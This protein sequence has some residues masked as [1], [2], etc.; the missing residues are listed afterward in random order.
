MDHRW[1]VRQALEVG[2]KLYA[3]PGSPISGQLL[4]ASSSGGYVTTNAAVPVMT[5]VHVTIGSESSQRRG[6]HRIAGYVVRTDARGVGIEWQ[7]FAPQPV[8]A[9]IEALKARPSAEGRR[10]SVGVQSPFVAHYCPRPLT[11]KQALGAVSHG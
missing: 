2:V 6:L 1:G 10:T 4:N 3:R 8:L 11:I 7:E 5:R 9:L